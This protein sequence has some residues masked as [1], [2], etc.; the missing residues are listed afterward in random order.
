MSTSLDRSFTTT[1]VRNALWQMHPIKS[2]G[3]DGFLPLF[4]QKHWDLVGDSVPSLCLRILHRN[5]DAS[6]IDQTL[7]ILI[8]KVDDPTRVSQFRLINF[9]NEIYKTVQNVLRLKWSR[10]WKRSSQG[11]KMHLGGGVRF[12]RM[13]LWDTNACKSWEVLILVHRGIWG[14]N[15]IWVK[16]IIEWSGLSWM[17]LWISWGSR[18]LGLRRLWIVYDLHHS[19]VD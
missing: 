16:P 13:L 15:L 6:C 12:S 18:W 1:G 3:L 7:I 5:N 19:L 11:H 8:L 10:L 2:P 4:F 9:C 14:L 17:L